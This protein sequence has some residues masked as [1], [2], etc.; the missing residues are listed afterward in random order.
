[1]QGIGCNKE[2]VCYKFETLDNGKS[3]YQFSGLMIMLLLLLKI[4]YPS[5]VRLNPC[6]GEGMVD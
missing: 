6:R 2:V 1:M 5:P 3:F 4:F